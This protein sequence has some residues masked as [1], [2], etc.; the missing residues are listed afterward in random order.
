MRYLRQQE[1]DEVK[2]LREEGFMIKDI[3]KRFNV[4]DATISNIV[5]GKSAPRKMKSLGDK[6][7]SPYDP[8]E[9][10]EE[11]FSSFPD[12]VLFQPVRERDFIG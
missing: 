11:D 9:F 7:R 3:A 10:I 1:V 12:N 4:C 6:I 5:N 8:V 2:K